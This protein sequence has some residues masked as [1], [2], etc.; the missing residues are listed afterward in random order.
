MHR[1][2][3]ELKFLT[4]VHCKSRRLTEEQVKQV[5]FQNFKP[6]KYIHCTPYSAI[7]H[8]SHASPGLPYHI[9]PR[10]IRRHNILCAHLSQIHPRFGSRC[11]CDHSTPS[12]R[13]AHAE[14]EI[15]CGRA[16][17]VPSEEG[18]F[19]PCCLMLMESINRI[20][21]LEL[22]SYRERAEE[23]GD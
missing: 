21:F 8:R 9:F 22:A 20:V 12:T 10:L 23:S 15:S 2:S 19:G 11:W 16:R 4:R 3:T 17:L 7:M 5:T 1:I 6:F 14:C 18:R 13:L